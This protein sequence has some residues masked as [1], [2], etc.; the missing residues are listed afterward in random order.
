MFSFFV[1]STYLEQLVPCYTEQPG[2]F[3]VRFGA[4]IAFP[5]IGH[6]MRP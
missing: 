1:Y 2:T 5:L 6:H 4:N 3:F